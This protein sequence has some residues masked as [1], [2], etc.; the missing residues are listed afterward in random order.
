MMRR[1]SLQLCICG[2]LLSMSASARAAWSVLEPVVLGFTA[3]SSTFVYIEKNAQTLQPDSA[4]RAVRLDVRTGKELAHTFARTDVESP[5][6]ERSAFQKWLKKNP[7]TC[8]RGPRSR[9]G[10]YT[11]KMVLKGS[12]D[13][14]GR[15]AQQKYTFE[16]T[17][18]DT[19]SAR[20]FVKLRALLLQ[21]RKSIQLFGL[22]ARSEWDLDG[23]VSP[24]W[25]PDGQHLALVEFRAGH[26]TRDAGWMD[27]RMV[28]LGRNLSWEFPP[29]RP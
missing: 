18:P 19:E 24:C 15:W 16:A 3:D 21:G 14:R 7:A 6:P 10:S 25:S 13:V 29:L 4:V 8:A 11:L 26:G 20:S 9:D 23:V 28:T 2:A 22:E 1:R 17:L 27:V 5:D 12:G